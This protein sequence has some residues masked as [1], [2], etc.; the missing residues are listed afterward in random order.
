MKK[1]IL[2]ILVVLVCVSAVFAAG[3]NSIKA[4]VVPYGFQISTSSAEGQDAVKSRYGIGLSAAFK[5]EFEGSGLFTEAG[6][7]WDT[8]LM[9]YSKPA[10]THILAFVG[11]G[12]E[13]AINEKFACSA[14][15]DLAAD[16]LLY[17][18]KASETLTVMVGLDG[19]YALNEN[20][21]VFLG[22]NGSFGFAK[23]D[24]TKYVNYRIL[25]VLGASYIF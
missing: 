11:G 1:S 20:L 10:F 21:E 3:T 13:L 19:S 6:L 5:H 8:F 12:Y 15:L 24:S 16:T 22:C 7:A 18:K 9:P 2:L 14:S 17:N 23:K 25:P 4:S